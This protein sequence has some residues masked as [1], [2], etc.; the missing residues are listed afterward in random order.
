VSGGGKTPQWVDERVDLSQFAGQ[1]ILLRFEYVTDDAVNGPGFLLDDIR[2]PELNFEDQGENGTNGWQAAGWVLT[3]NTLSE[4]WLVQV[5][6]AGNNGVQV[7]RMNVGADGRGE[8]TIK[9]AGS[10]DNVM[11]TVNALAP[12]TTESA[13]YSYNIAAR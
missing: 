3:D 2:I 4:H 12:V 9:D 5:V 10:L 13:S 1:K 11:L 8:V 6:T 7:Q